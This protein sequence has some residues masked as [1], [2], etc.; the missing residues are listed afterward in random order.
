MAMMGG[1]DAAYLF[2]S[3]TPRFSEKKLFSPRDSGSAGAAFDNFRRLACHGRR[4]MVSFVGHA[5]LDGLQ[6]YHI[7]VLLLLK[8]G[9]A[10]LDGEREIQKRD[11]LHN[12]GNTPT[13]K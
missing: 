1:N 4:Q 9:I 3:L 2:C 7:L 5:S 13:T 10:E 6:G 8:G 11:S 12:W